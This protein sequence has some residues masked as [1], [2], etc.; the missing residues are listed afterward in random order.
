MNLS[1][2]P[3]ILFLLLAGLCQLALAE[4]FDPGQVYIDK[5]VCPGEWCR[6]GDWTINEELLLYDQPYSR[7][8]PIGRLRKGQTVKALTGNA[9]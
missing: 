6:F 3:T 1:S 8:P 9:S 5:D 7:S 4:E 2:M